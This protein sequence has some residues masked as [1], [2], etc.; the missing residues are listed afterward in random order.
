MFRALL[1]NKDAQ[2]IKQNAASFLLVQSDRY[3]SPLLKSL[4]NKM[5]RRLTNT[6]FNL[7]VAIMAFRHSSMGLLI[8]ELGGYVCGFDHALRDGRVNCARPLPGL[9]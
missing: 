2:P 1:Q 5:D 7:F 3:L 6:F 8:S 4:D 9:K